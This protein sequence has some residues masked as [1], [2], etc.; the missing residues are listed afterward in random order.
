MHSADNAVARCPSVCHTSVFCLNGYI[1]P[2]SFFTMPYQW[3]VNNISL[4]PTILVF[5]TKADGNIPT[6]TCLKTGASN[7][8]VIWK[9]SRFST[10]TR[11]ISQMMQDT[12]LVTIWKANRKPH[13]IFRMALV[14]MTFSDLFKVT[15][16]QRQ[17]TWKWYNIQLL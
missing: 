17:I 10:K 6:G 3:P 13:P 14:W 9:K 12:A 1:Y 4:C 2:Q 11:F 15:I 8:R 7:A 5:H 16:I